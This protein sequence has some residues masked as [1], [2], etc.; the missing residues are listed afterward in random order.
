MHLC[1]FL[2][3]TQILFCCC[4]CFQTRGYS[5]YVC[6]TFAG[7]WNERKICGICIG[8]LHQWDHWGSC[9]Q[10]NLKGLHVIDQRVPSCL[11][12]SLFVVNG[13]FELRARNFNVAV[14]LHVKPRK[15]QTLKC[16]NTIKACTHTHTHTLTL[17]EVRCLNLSWHLIRPSF[18]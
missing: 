14:F 1:V 7:E 3:H 18:P 12:P 2:S 11:E 17:C 10:R 15:T 5:L 8:K 16:T 4:F 13:V 6:N 9:T